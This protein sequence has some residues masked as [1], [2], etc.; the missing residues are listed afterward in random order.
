MK[1]FNIIPVFVIPSILCCLHANLV[2]QLNVKCSSITQSAPIA[3]NTTVCIGDTAIIVASSNYGHPLYWYDAPTQ[4]NLI[5]I[6]NTLSI[7]ASITSYFWI[8][9]TDGSCTS[10]RT[11]VRLRVKNQLPPPTAVDDFSCNRTTITLQSNATSGATGST[12]HWYDAPTQGN[13]VHSGPHYTFPAATD[14][15]WIEEIEQLSQGNTLDNGTDQASFA[16]M[17]RGYFFTAPTDFT[18]TGLR[19]PTDRSNKPQSVEV[20]QFNNSGPPSYPSTSNNFNSLFRANNVASTSVIPCQITILEGSTIAI[21]GSRGNNSINSYSSP[22]FQTSI[23]GIP[24]T[25]Q[26][27]GMQSS[28]ASNNAQNIWKESQNPIG[29]IEMYYDATFGCTSTRT[30]VKAQVSQP[31]YASKD[32][33][34]RTNS[35]CTKTESGIDWTYYFHDSDPDKLLFAIAHDPYQLGNNSFSATVDITTSLHPDNPS[36]FNNGIFKAEN[37]AN[38]H[39]YFAMGRYWNFSYSGTLSDP[40]HVRFYFSEDE[41]NAIKTAADH[42]AQ[43]SYGGQNNLYVSSVHWFNTLHQNYNPNHSLQADSLTNSRIFSQYN[44]K[45]ASTNNGINYVQLEDI[46]SATGGTAAVSVYPGHLLNA[47]LINFKAQK[48]TKTAL[49]SWK[50][51]NHPS[52]Y[53]YEIQKSTDGIHFYSL[54]FVKNDAAVQ[55][56]KYIDNNPS[57]AANYYRLKIINRNYQFSFSDIRVLDFEYSHS[58]PTVYPNPFSN[59]LHLEY[60]SQ[61]EQILELRILNSKGQ[62]VDEQSTRIQQGNNRSTLDNCNK[63]TAGTYYLQA[64]C[65]D[66]SKYFKIIKQ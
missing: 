25:L 3:Q 28:I 6:G 2:A 40:I 7:Q 27:C 56:Y 60:F 4:G 62:I 36:D 20:I 37:L 15:F 59:Q 8:E 44:Y 22:N 30:K 65:Q 48:T 58:T 33:T 16:G 9:E 39:A 18:I 29:R 5:Q 11:R 34:I 31:E 32:S 42:W 53:Q 26:R 24:L 43:Q 52:I 10:N 57:A 21:I 64:V 47:H 41:K 61:Q 23:S 50:M 38:Q 1:L 51:N 55:D 49:L 19:V 13:L 35:S 54:G 63:L 14:S 46:T 45:N 12:L 66:F 17:S